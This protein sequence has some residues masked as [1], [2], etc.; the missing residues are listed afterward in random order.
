MG[1]LLQQKQ[2]EGLDGGALTPTNHKSL[3]Q[4]VHNVVAS[5]SSCYEERLRDSKNRLS[6]LTLWTDNLKTEKILD[7]VWNRSL[8]A[9]PL[10]L[11][12][13]LSSSGDFIQ[14]VTVDMYESGVIVETLTGTV[15]RDSN[16]FIQSIDWV[17]T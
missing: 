1:N 6:Q 8:S 13:T 4:L 2:I 15:S 3:R 9:L 7:I 10:T 14:S 17:R 12:F 11:P 5:V 16:N